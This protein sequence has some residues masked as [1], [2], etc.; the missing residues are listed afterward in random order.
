MM[1]EFLVLHLS[2]GS[3]SLYITYDFNLSLKLARD[4]MIR[5]TLICIYAT[6]KLQI[7]YSCLQKSLF[8]VDFSE[9][10]LQIAPLRIVFRFKIF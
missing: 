8:V 6:L 3:T 10:H 7:E 4:K 2:S 1:S 9:K 5:K